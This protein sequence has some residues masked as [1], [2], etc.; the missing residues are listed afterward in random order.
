MSYRFG[1]AGRG[2]KLCT[3][4]HG[5]QK[6]NRN[7]F[8]SE[9]NQMVDEFYEGQLPP[10]A[11]KNTSPKSSIA[12]LETHLIQMFFEKAKA[13]CKEIICIKDMSE[14][15]SLFESNRLFDDER[16]YLLFDESNKLKDLRPVIYHLASTEEAR[17]YVKSRQPL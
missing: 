9:T 8:K 1:P 3:H 5:D 7:E 16:Y 17:R 11:Q 13:E 2:K 14:Y 10:A 15:I 4:V 12:K 6:Y